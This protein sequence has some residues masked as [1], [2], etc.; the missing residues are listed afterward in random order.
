MEFIPFIAIDV[1]TAN[2]DSATICQVGM[3]FFTS[4]TESHVSCHLIDPECSFNPRFRAI[5]GITPSTVRGARTWDSFYSA[6]SFFTDPQLDV[7]VA[8]HTYFDRE[9]IRKACE[10]YSLRPPTPRLWLDTCAIARRTWPDLP[11]HKLPTLAAHFGISYQAHNA[12]E[13]ARCA[14]QILLQAIRDSDKTMIQI[15]EDHLSA[16]MGKQVSIKV[17]DAPSPPVPDPP[18]PEKNGIRWA[19]PVAAILAVACLLWFAFHS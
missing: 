12:G 5:H 17:L 8:S 7:I 16:E 19:W 3:C 13:D 14:G 10:R 18:P 15:M 9:A 11:N 1:E 2:T 6:I 4:P